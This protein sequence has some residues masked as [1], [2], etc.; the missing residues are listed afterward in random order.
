[1]TGRRLTFGDAL[2]RQLPSIR[3]GRRHL[4]L[5]LPEP[6]RVNL[7]MLWRTRRACSNGHLFLRRGTGCST[8][9][10]QRSMGSC[11]AS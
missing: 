4:A 6:A 10:P 8:S 11:N 5:Y 1:M 9:G 2:H 3:S 7:A